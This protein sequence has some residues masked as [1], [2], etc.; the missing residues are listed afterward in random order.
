[1]KTVWCEECKG[2]SVVEDERDEQVWAYGE[3]FWVESLDCGHEI[4]TPK[5]D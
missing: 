5:E 3:R 1:M 4:V 2:P